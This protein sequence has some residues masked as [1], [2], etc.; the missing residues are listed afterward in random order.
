MNNINEMDN[1]TK[2][3][4]IASLNASCIASA[5]N[6]H[7]TE[8]YAYAKYYRLKYVAYEGYVLQYRKKI[9]K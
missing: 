7:Y 8:L 9:I 5:D 4:V 1:I 6:F 2:D 3:D